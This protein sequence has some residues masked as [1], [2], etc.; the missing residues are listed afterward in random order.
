MLN[1]L[2]SGII[3]IDHTQLLLS[4]MCSIHY[5]YF[6]VYFSNTRPDKLD[7]F[8]ILFMVSLSQKWSVRS[9]E[10]PTLVQLESETNMTIS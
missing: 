5:V 8:L 1:T 3:D 10:Q 4:G 9:N 2:F 7:E 6:Y